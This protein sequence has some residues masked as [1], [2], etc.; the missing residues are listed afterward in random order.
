MKV[1]GMRMTYYW[2][3]NFTFNLSIFLVTVA[4][5]WLTAAFWFKMNFF[6]NTDWK[7][8]SLVF[9]GWGLCQVSLAF[10]FSV[11][12][13]NSQTASIVGY[14]MSIWACTIAVTMNFT[15]WHIPHKMEAFAYLIPSF[16][17]MRMFYNMALDCAYSTC[18]QS[19]SSVDQETFNCLIAIYAGALVY[20]V[21]AIY[22]NQ[23]VPSVYGVPKHPL[24]CL[25]RFFRP[26][27]TLY[28]AVY[29]KDEENDMD[30]ASGELI[31]EDDD[32][33]NER[34]HV[35]HIDKSEYRRYPLVAKDIRKVYPGVNGRK[36]KVAN[37][38]LSLKIN[39]GELFGLLGPNG[40]GKTTFISQ[41]TGMYRP[42]SGNAWVSGYDIRDNLE[43]VQLQIG[44][45]PQFDILWDDLS[46]AEH[47]LFYARL[48]GV[49][50]EEEEKMV[51]K[52]IKE[53]QLDKERDML[54][55]KLPLGMKRRLSIA[56]SLVA[57]PKIVFLDEPTT[58]LDPETRRQLWNIL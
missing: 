39:K 50:P 18:Y 52:A 58:G 36:P 47:L 41:L 22:L 31:G 5:Y 28:K 16:P 27:S 33:K 10:F 46:V 2:L 53:V 24:F 25:R 8:L 9:F 44:V 45:C 13:N 1:N 6:V 7:L 54:T 38:N 49:P 55:K 51:N 26:K 17:Y 3:V 40:A 35:H 57:N 56:I 34:K 19:I 42:T 12:I 15:V 21:L 32:S 23:V 30:D 29:G 48:K 14:T 37:K 4:I 20:F 43:L 11:F